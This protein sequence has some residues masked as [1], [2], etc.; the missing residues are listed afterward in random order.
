MGRRHRRRWLD[1]IVLGQN[2]AVGEAHVALQRFLLDLRRRGVMLAVCSKNEDATA[3]LPFREH[4][5]MVLK[6]NHIAVFM[7]NWSDKANNL[8][9]IAA[10]LNIGIDS[11]VF[12]DDNPV[13]RDQVRQVLPEVAVPELTEDP[14]DYI[15]LLANAGYFE[16]IGLSEEDL[17]RADFYQANA[18]RVSLQK[19][20]NLEDYL[21]SLQ[22]VATISPFNAVG[23]V[24]IAQLINKSNQFNLTTRRYSEAE[25]EAFEND[26][27]KFCLQV[28][29]ADRFGDNG[30]ISVVIFDIGSEEWSCD[31]WLMSCRVL[32]RRVE[33]LVLAT[34][35]SAA[36]NAGAKRLEG[37]LHSNQEEWTCGR[38][39]CQARLHQALGP[40]RWRD[41]LGAR[42]RDILAPELPMRV[43]YTNELIPA[44]SLFVKLSSVFDGKHLR[45][46]ADCPLTPSSLLWLFCLQSVLGY[47]MLALNAFASA[48]SS[49]PHCD[50]TYL[51][52]PGPS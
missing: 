6:E 28:R 20:G 43:I 1:G 52:R 23:R 18:E 15:G 33:E 46:Y 11:L 44:V 49:L 27:F 10:T 4:P 37:N 42:P 22:M 2:S 35:A 24:R 26:P 17:A 19:V 8:R 21:R 12:L 32:G 40:S 9:E 5:E 36:S 45:G 39:L 3:R 13:E 7:A 16:A 30:M 34:V 47:Y 29:L 38:A 48:A 31:T 25:V 51:L 41:Y 50:G 14:A